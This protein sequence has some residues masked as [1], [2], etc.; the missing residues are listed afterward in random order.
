MVGLMWLFFMKACLQRW[1]DEKQKGNVSTQVSCPQ[2]GT[3]YLI[4]FPRLGKR[5]PI[6]NSI[7]SSCF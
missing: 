7:M 5:K 3:Q 4:D 6:H 2:C 1:I